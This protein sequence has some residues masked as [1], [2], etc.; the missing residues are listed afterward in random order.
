MSKFDSDLGNVIILASFDDTPLTQPN[1]WQNAEKAKLYSE[2]CNAFYVR[3]IKVLSQY[4][5]LNL[6]QRRLASLPFYIERAASHIVDGQT[7]LKLDSQNGS[8]IAK[9]PKHCPVTNESQN[10][11]FFSKSAS[12]G[13][14]VPVV[15]NEAQIITIKIDTIDEVHEEKLHCN[16][17][18]WFDFTGKNLDC[19]DNFQLLKPGKVA[20][21]SACCGHRWLNNKIFTP[22]VLSLRE[23]LLATRI[24]WQNF[25]KVITKK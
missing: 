17:F 13:L 16:Q 5:D 24:D 20:F 7:P 11:R 15:V 3:E 14:I 22:R 19:D 21:A 8:W 9:Q 12:V 1:L 6:M 23:M 2:L 25:A 18:G 4:Q 10:T